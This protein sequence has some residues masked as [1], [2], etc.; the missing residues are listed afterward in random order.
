MLNS[1]L[2]IL[3]QSLTAWQLRSFRQLVQSPYFNKNEKVV[4]CLDGLLSVAPD[5]SLLSEK[6]L[7]H[8]VFIKES[9]NH[10][11]LR[12]V[13]TDLT[14]LLET[15][16]IQEVLFD[17]V[18]LQKQLLLRKLESME[19]E[20]YFNQHLEQGRDLIE[21]SKLGVAR[22]KNIFILDEISFSFSRRSNSR[23]ADH[24]LQR[25]SDSMDEYY[26]LMRLK[27]T[28]EMINRANVLS[29][30]YTIPSQDYIEQ[31]LIKCQFDNPLISIYKSILD[32]LLYPAAEDAYADLKLQVELHYRKIEQN[33]LRDVYVFLQNYCIRMINN[34]K[35]NYLEEL[36]NIYNLMI[37]QEVIFEKDELE[38]LQFKN[39]IT[40]SLR[41]NKIQ[42]TEHFIS[43]YQ[44]KLKSDL[45]KNAVSF[46]TARIHYAKK[47][48]REALRVMRSVEFTDIYYHLD[49][50][51]LQ[52]K[53][54]FETDDLEPLFS[55]ITTVTT[56]LKRS[57]LISSYQ[58]T[59]YLS[60]IS[61]I[62]KLAKY[63]SGYKV[64]LAT[65]TEEIHSGKDIADIGWLRTQVANLA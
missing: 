53:I 30:A 37:D 36:F 18:F 58:R 26:V 59:V 11:K 32:L 63:K 50:K 13:M 29:E 9:F 40:L 44:N 7:F 24:T 61:Y 35:E 43:T 60:L 51:L 17:D 34:G 52:L 49:A 54:Y 25:L 10:Q 64:D 48:Y 55:L 57:S 8:M 2:L 39:I 5:F 12:Y 47:N 38:H 15:F 20:K 27:F 41:L 65:I 16:L 14:I 4:L 46:N 62:K 6:E 21:N 1:K 23:N 3:L 42:W 45:R 28:C 19:P 33:E 31:L 22:L 56:Y